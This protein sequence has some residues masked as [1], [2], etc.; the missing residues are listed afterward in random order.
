M[1]YYIPVDYGKSIAEIYQDMIVYIFHEKKEEP[2]VIDI[3]L[4]Y[5]LFLLLNIPIPRIF[6][7]LVTQYTNT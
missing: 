4:E 7:I 6:I 5:L 3:Y 2:G 1:Y